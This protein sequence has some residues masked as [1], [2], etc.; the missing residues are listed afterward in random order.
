VGVYGALVRAH[1]GFGGTSRASVCS[2]GR[3][4]GPHGDTKGY[5]GLSGTSRDSAE[6]GPGKTEGNHE[7]TEG[8]HRLA[9]GNLTQ[10]E[11][12]HAQ[13]VGRPDAT[14]ERAEGAVGTTA[15]AVETHERFVDL[16][17]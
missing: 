15:G 8:D 1:G 7:A 17:S 3:T 13:T 11:G 14:G 2:P 6:D 16:S 4:G 9:G 10:T 5:L 12:A